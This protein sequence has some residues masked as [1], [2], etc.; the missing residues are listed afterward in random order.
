MPN[1]E[2]TEVYAAQLV[3]LENFVYTLVNNAPCQ[4]AEDYL[5]MLLDKA[6]VIGDDYSYD[7]WKIDRGFPL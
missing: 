7:Q 2:H 1:P 4:E 6:K 3:L 5:M